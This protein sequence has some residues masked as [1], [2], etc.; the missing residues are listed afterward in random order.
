M[1]KNSLKKVI[2]I[3][4][5]ATADIDTDEEGLSGEVIDSVLSVYCTN[6]TGITYAAL[7]PKLYSKTNVFTIVVL[8]CN[9]WILI[10]KTR[11]FPSRAMWVFL[12]P[13]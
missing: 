3:L 6:Y 10:T 7:L 4:R 12:V 5:N 9:H 8:S 2:K 13:M 11:S 1:A